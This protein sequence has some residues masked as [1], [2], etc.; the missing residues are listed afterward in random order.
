M[1]KEEGS[2]SWT[3]ET[4]NARQVTSP[5]GL[6]IQHAKAIKLSKMA[7]TSIA[8][9]RRYVVRTHNEG[10]AN[11]C[12]RLRARVRRRVCECMDEG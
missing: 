6:F 2:S 7:N 1:V 12:W 8:I 4:F 10:P 9:V 3:K 11:L 5:E